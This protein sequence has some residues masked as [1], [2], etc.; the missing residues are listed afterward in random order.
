M[1]NLELGRF[2]RGKRVFVTGHTGFKGSW[3]CRILLQ[4]GAEVTGYAL[5]PEGKN[6]FEL[7]GVEKEMRSLTG[8]I[9]SHSDLQ[10]AYDM[11]R[12]DVVLH[13]AAQPLV[14]EGFRTPRYTYEVNVLGTVNLLE[15]LRGEDRTV[16]FVNVTTDKVYSN[17]EWC[18]GYRESDTLD[19]HDP[20]SNSK[21]C[22]ELITGCYRHSFFSDSQVVLST[23]RA[24]NVIGGGDF[25]ANRLLPDCVRAVEQGKPVILRNPAATRPYQHVLEPLL[26]YLMVAAEQSRRPE[27]AGSYNVGPGEDGCVSNQTLARLFCQAWGEG[28]EWKA[29]KSADLYQEANLLRLDCSKIAARFGW[30]PRWTVKTAVDKTVEWAKARRDGEDIAEVMDRQLKEYLTGGQSNA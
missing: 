6:L 10:A 9:R 17:R 29:A 16:S 12:P 4:L 23:L 13:L 27:A 3:L 2:Y 24:G 7:T 30:K 21:S 25:A 8:D 14:Q 5:A 1:E 22:S 19:G 28:A 15:C 20:Y 18:W 11:A 26:A